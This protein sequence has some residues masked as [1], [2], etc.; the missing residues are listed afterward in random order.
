MK[1]RTEVLR[2]VVRNT[3]WD[4]YDHLGTLVVCNLLSFVICMAA[5]VVPF[6]MAEVTS[7]WWVLLCLPLATASCCAAGMLRVT[8]DMAVRREAG[9]R[10]FFAG[11]AALWRPTATLALLSLAVLCLAAANVVFYVNVSAARP[12][13]GL[14]LAAFCL[15]VTLAFFVCMQ[16]VLPAATELWVEHAPEPNGSVSGH[17]VVHY[18]QLPQAGTPRKLGASLGIGLTLL[19]HAPMVAA[20]LFTNLAL[21]WVLCLATGVGA[22]LLAPGVTCLALHHAYGETVAELVGLGDR[23]AGEARSLGELV[24]PWEGRREPGSGSGSP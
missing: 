12:L 9:A 19:L 23:R 24:R 18:H 20:V 1:G 7:L 5:G 22:V 14:A 3:F 10:D 21:F 6:A 15:W 13:V 16:F 11:M 4:A 8:Y 17:P 2:R